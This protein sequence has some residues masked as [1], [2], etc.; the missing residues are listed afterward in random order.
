MNPIKT[1]RTMFTAAPHRPELALL[2]EP[3]D[4]G[5]YQLRFAGH[6]K[7]FG[8]YATEADALRIAELNFDKVRLITVTHVEH[9][10]PQPA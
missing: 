10:E 5:G 7:G 6:K 2:V 9:P 8:N 3:N 1:L 4:R